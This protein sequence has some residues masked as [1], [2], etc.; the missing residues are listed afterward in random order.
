MVA[1]GVTDFRTAPLPLKDDA[2]S[3][4][5]QKLLE[6]FSAESQTNVRRAVAA[7]IILSGLFVCATALLGWN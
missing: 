5:D 7:L 6:F 3:R 2:L 4:F 1:M